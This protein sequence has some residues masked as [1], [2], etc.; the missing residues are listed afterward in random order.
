MEA[1]RAPQGQDQLWLLCWWCLHWLKQ[2]QGL[3]VVPF[4]GSPELQRPKEK[5]MK[6]RETRPHSISIL[7]FPAGKQER[8]TYEEN[9]EAP[10]RRL[11]SISRAVGVT[12]A[13]DKEERGL[14]HK[15]GL[16]KKL[17]HEA[18]HHLGQR[19]IGT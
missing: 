10:V 18:A 5:K 14:T 7:I 3:E 4:L 15:N 17:P 6:S 12:T 8:R 16:H 13:G 19:G 2:W 9:W 1:G 11:R